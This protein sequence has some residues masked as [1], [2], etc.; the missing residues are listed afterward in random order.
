MRQ[1]SKVLKQWGVPDSVKFSQWWKHERHMHLWSGAA[2]R[3]H[4]C[5]G[6]DLPL[7]WM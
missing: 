6:V 2:V 3:N 5:S 1:I 7:Q 4:L